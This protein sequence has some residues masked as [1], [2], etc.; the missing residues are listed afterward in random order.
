[1]TIEVGIW[2]RT[3]FAGGCNGD[4]S[5]AVGGRKFKLG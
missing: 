1:M 2:S 4:G 3:Y 5:M